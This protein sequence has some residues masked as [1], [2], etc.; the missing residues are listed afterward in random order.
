MRRILWT[1]LCA[2]VALSC[3]RETVPETTSLPVSKA[4]KDAAG[5]VSVAQENACLIPGEA[6]VYVSED[7]ASRL[8]DG[9]MGDVL[10]KS[11]EEI[12]LV[13]SRIGA[14]SFTRLFPDA[15]EYEPRTRREGLHRW[16][17]VEYNKNLSIKEAKPVL[18]AV[19][20]IQRVEPNFRIR[21][22]VTVNDPYWSDMWGQNNTSNPGYDVN[23]KPVWDNYTM[24]DPKVVVAVVDG[25][26]QLDHPDL[27]A[28]VA[29]SG[30][31]NYVRHNSNIKQHSHGT[32]VAGTIAAVN[33]NGKGVTG[34]AG[35]NAAAGKKGVTLLSLQV[36]ETQDNGQDATASSF[37]TAIKEAADKGAHIS[38]NSWGYNFDF[39]DDGKVE[40]NEL[41]YARNSHEN[42]ERSF[43]Q[44]VDYFSKYAG[45]DN[46]GNQLPN[47]PMKGGLVI[48]A[49]G[50]DNIPY[51]APGNY[52]GC[53]S[54]GAINK[55][56]AR[57]SFSN[58][59]DW[60]DLCA[61][62]VSVRSTN[63]N[64]NY[65]T[66]SGTSMAC[67]HVS[68]VAALIVSYF[69]G[70]GFT[71]DELR[72]RLINGAKDIAP[73]TG[74][75]PIGPLVNAYSSFQLNGTSNA[76]ER[77][78]DIEV[79]P[80]GHNIR[81][82]FK[83]TNA[84]AYMIMAATQKSAIVG[85][86]Y[87]NPPSNVIYATT[88]AAASEAPGTP[89]SVVLA[90]LKPSTEY[91]V[92][93]VGYSYDKKYSEL[94]DIE[95]LTTAENRKPVIEINDYPEGG[96]TFKHHE[97][98]S[99]PVR[100]SDPDGDALTVTF[101]PRGSR[102]SLDPNNGSEENYNFKLMCP[103]VLNPGSFQ[104]VIRVKDEIGVSEVRTIQFTVLPNSE[105]VLVKEFPMILLEDTEKEQTI[106]LTQYIQDP[107]EE[108]LL[109][110]ANSVNKGVATAEVSDGGVLSL[111]AVSEGVCNVKVSAEDA[112]GARVDAVLKILVRYPDSPEVSFT[113]D[114]VITGGSI[115]II[116]SVE[117]DS[118]TVRVISASGVV[119]YETVATISAANPLELELDNLAPGVYTVEVTYKGQ[120][121]TY[122][123]VKR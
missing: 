76:P 29:A 98:V 5:T 108:D 28:N 18:E 67:P 87:Q 21:E 111:K 56:G 31:Y 102:A 15:G 59:G 44:A 43:T 51:G 90:G 48:F 65:A 95:K 12:D 30:H 66:F 55:T 19:S 94:S 107:D 3:T 38:Q 25:G 83:A 39:N 49:A 63:I 17:I 45:C 116:P 8:G 9:A 101:D 88:L 70:Q 91:Y 13:S 77:V 71:A 106:D 96:Y 114:T 52:D 50:N 57:A 37:A 100:F 80:T 41:N 121:Y 119:V 123:I 68:G 78:E 20:G 27:A 113:G 4:G 26:I 6:I 42:P 105:P 24:G 81:V 14:S 97:I 33:N 53:V 60:V 86:D 2:L 69:G 23:C 120:V 35:G 64:G 72:A 112:D 110:R 85:A 40:G 99:I 61:P 46:N 79:S 16:F 104:S 122:T 22:N 32:H 7:L 10:R 34:V 54:V 11:S 84:Y 118:A 58:Y 117:E 1:V 75:K 93:V 103:L 73:S 47:S 74:S 109:F 92:A 62:G 89:H 82:D 36:F 115:T